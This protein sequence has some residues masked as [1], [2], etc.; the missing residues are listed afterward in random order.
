[1]NALYGQQLAQALDYRDQEFRTAARAVPDDDH[2]IAVIV[3]DP[4]VRRQV[5]I[6]AGVG[7]G[8][9]RLQHGRS[10]MQRSRMAGDVAWPMGGPQH[11][12]TGICRRGV[13]EDFGHFPNGAGGEQAG[14]GVCARGAGGCSVGDAWLHGGDGHCS[15]CDPR[16]GV[17]AA[18]AGAVAEART[19]VDVITGGWDKD[20]H[21]APPAGGNGT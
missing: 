16:C 21:K 13:Q 19:E 15:F 6:S 2:L 17:V 18:D 1:M 7:Y 20:L 5:S 14:A 9:R 4:K 8:P 3:Q 10:V 11:A 12:G